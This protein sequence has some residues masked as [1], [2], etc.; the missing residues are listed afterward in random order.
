MPQH[1]RVY[2]QTLPHFITSTIVY[3]IPVFCREDYFAVLSDNFKFY[4]ENRGLQLHAY[5]IMPNHFHAVCSQV[6]GQ[7]SAVVRD[8]KK[9]TAREIAR[10]L[11]E[12]GRNLWLSAM[13]K[14]AGGSGVKVW[15][16]AFHPE[17]IHSKPFLEQK[18]AYLHNNPAR[19]GYVNDPCEWKHSSAGLYYRDSK[20]LLPIVLLE[21]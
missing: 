13:R 2:D 6:D 21:L 5:V 20:P 11:E 17:Q 12:D 8:L 4:I 18:L 7:L 14:A 15:D 3:W 19:A 1:F 9:Y 16:E 10:K